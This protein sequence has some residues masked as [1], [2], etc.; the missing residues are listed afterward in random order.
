MNGRSSLLLLQ[1]Y[2]DPIR[3]LVLLWIDWR[4]VLILVFRGLVLNL[5]PQHGQFRS[6]QMTNNPY[7]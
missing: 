2:K 6:L 1:K 7:F 3:D 5:A 4:S